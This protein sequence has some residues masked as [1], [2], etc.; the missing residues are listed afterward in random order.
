M[1][2]CR[3]ILL[4][5]FVLILPLTAMTQEGISVR[6][7][8]GR[9]TEKVSF[10]PTRIA[11][12]EARYIG[13]EYITAADSVIMKNCGI[14]LQNDLDFSP[15]FENVPLDTFFMRHME[16]ETMTML[17]WTRLG[18]SYV[19]KLEVE[20]PQNKIRL[21]YRLFSTESGKEINKNRMETEKKFYRTL[22]HQIANDIYKFLTGDEG[23]YRTRIVYSKDLD[24]GAQELY[25]A[26][27]DGQNER[28]LTNNGSINLLPRF[29][30]DG[31]YVYFTSYMDGEPR[32]YMLNLNDNH[33]DKITDYP[34]LNTAVSVAPDGK[35]FACVLSKDGNSELYLLDRKGKIIKRL[36]YSWAIETA[37][38]WSPD[39]KELAFTSDRTGSPQIYIMDI[40]FFDLKRLTFSGN[41]NDSPCWSPRGDRIA[42]V[43][44]DRNFK[45][46]IIDVTGRNFRILTEIGDN[47]NPSFSPDGNHIVFSSNRLGSKELY[48]MDLFGHNQRKITIGGGNTNPAWSPYKN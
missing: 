35:S 5:F 40:E 26:D 39:G 43:T 3:R 46:C 36:S 19:V 31:E 23:V 4:L 21:G 8:R 41:Y 33:I 24:N 22:V 30:P 7:V 9:L 47:E 38:T 18:A 44:R 32:I 13:I 45:I 28:Q 14:I 10:E 42:F 29:T 27:Y 11:V 1:K 2:S 20:Y 16:I 25:I 34:G 37:P 12:E 48:T 6:D 17:A 15:F